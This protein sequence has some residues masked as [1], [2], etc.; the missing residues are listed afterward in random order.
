MDENSSKDHRKRLRAR[1]DINGIKAFHDYEKLELLLTYCIPYRDTKPLAKALIEKF[2]NISA[3]FSADSKDL[4]GIA[5]ISERT[6]LFLRLIKDIGESI[7]HSELIER[8]CIKNPVE[9][10]DYFRLYFTHKKDEEFCAVF[11]NSQNRIIC[12]D[13][14]FKGTINRVDVYPRNLIDRILRLNAKNIIILHNHP[15]GSLKPSDDDSYLTF[16]LA[17][18]LRN[19]ESTILDHI[20]ICSNKYYSFSEEGMISDIYRKIDRIEKEYF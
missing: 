10:V 3:V 16:R 13:S 9:I 15:G 4:Q 17:L 5:G 7:K 2:K 6:A 14:L 19:V 11:L 12:I 8:E 1:Y 18:A 20:I